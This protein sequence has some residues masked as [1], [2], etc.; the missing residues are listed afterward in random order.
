MSRKL[1]EVVIPKEEA[2]F[3]L[4]KHGRWHNQDGEFQ[5]RKIIYYFHSCIRKDRDGY[6]LV[7]RH[8]NFREKVYFPYEDTP[9]FVFDV[10]KQEEVILVLNTK[11]RIRLKPK[12]LFIRDDSLYMHAGED[13]IKFSGQALVKIADLI[14]D[15]NGQ[16]FIRVKGRRYRISQI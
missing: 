8:R 4:D 15:E 5:H 14:E 12:K 2:L 7:Q 13:R 16:C 9:L 10:V 3:W 1:K 11:K 6:H